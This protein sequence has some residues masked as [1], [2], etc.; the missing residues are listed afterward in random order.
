MLRTPDLHHEVLAGL[1][2]P[3]AAVADRWG[4]RRMLLLGYAIIASGPLSWGTGAD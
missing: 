1:L 4:R 3:W 2:V